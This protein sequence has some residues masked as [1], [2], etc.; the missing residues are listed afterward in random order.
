MHVLSMAMLATCVASCWPGKRDALVLCWV[1]CIAT[2]GG[3][4]ILESLSPFMLETLSNAAGRSLLRMVLALV[5]AFLWCLSIPRC[6]TPATAGR[7][8]A[9]SLI[10]IA[11]PILD[12]HQ[13]IESYQ[14][15]VSSS[16]QARRLDRAIEHLQP[17]LELAPLSMVE[18][19][20]ATALFLTTV[21]EMVRI[22]NWLASQ[23]GV[24]RGETEWID[25]C[26]GLLMLGRE[27][28]VMSWYPAATHHSPMA[29]TMLIL[30]A[31]QSQDWNTMQRWCQTVL[32][33]PIQD[34][35]PEQRI[36]W[37]ELMAEACG[38]LGDRASA[39]RWLRKGIDEFP[40]QRDV[41][42]LK[43]AIEL[44]EQ[45]MLP[46]AIGLIDQLLRDSPELAPQIEPHR[47]R[48]LNHSCLP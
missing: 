6:Q 4:Y 47:R 11:V 27:A 3:F 43:L 48:F 13:R 36:T 39:A 31:R 40:S 28:E 25:R 20:S 34:A 16:V 42:G 29:Q 8:V 10:A 2:I 46:Q 7:W 33:Q 9:A 15:A 38:R 24:A 5:L 23:T 19:R 45:G 21:E 14:A 17:L 44:G 37:I 30:S 26:K 41:F 22:E 35:D 18:G 32:D 12:T 1:A